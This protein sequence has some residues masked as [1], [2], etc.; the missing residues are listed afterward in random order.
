MRFFS[1]TVVPLN[2]TGPF[3]LF[4]YRPE[5]TKFD[6]R[7][8]ASCMKFLHKFLDSGKSSRAFISRSYENRSIVT[9]RIYLFNIVALFS[10]VLGKQHDKNV[11]ML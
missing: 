8:H 2:M 4:F 7:N 6:P 10:M 9:K 5:L 3:W 1:S 11:K